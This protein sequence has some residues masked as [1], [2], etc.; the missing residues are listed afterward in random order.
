VPLWGKELGHHLTQ[1]HLGRG[2][3]P[4]QVASW[5]IQPFG[6]NIW[7]KSVGLLYHLF[8]EGVGSSSNTMSPGLRATSV[9][10]DILIH[11]AVWPTDT[12]RKI[13]WG[14]CPFWRMGLGPC[15]TCGGGRGLRPTCHVLSS[16]SILLATI[17]QR[18]RQ[19]GQTEQRSD[20]IGR[21]VL[22]SVA[23]KRFGLKSGGGAASVKYESA[24]GGLLC[25][26]APSVGEELDP[27]L[28]QCGVGRGLPPYQVAS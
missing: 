8:W 26:C 24:S 20:T 17:H 14:L 16:A 21:T 18:Y 9:P 13:K 27:H 23:Q 11:P 28:T 7:P 3:P 19:T 12:D 4:Y 2:L 6:H 15:L 22:Q 10:S 5:S 1:C 25:G